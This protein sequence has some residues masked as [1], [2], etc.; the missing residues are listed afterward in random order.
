MRVVFLGTP[1]FA[2]PSLKALAEAED[3][4]VELVIT[5]PD[6]PRS[7]NKWTPTPVKLCAEELGLPV[8]TPEKVNTRE[9][10]DLLRELAPDALVVI[11]YG[12]IIGKTL[13]SMFPDR[14]INI[15]GS[16]LPEYR[17]AAPIQ[18]AM[19][20]GKKETGLTSMLIER[21]MDA[22][23][24]LDKRVTPIAEDDDINT[25]T[26]RLANLAPELLL[27]TLR[28]IEERVQGAQ[29]QD[30]SLVTFAEKITREDGVLDFRNPV[31]KL[32][33]QVR[34][35]L[36]WPCATFVLNGEIYKVHEASIREAKGQAAPGTIV[37]AKDA[38]AIRAADG[39]LVI[40]KIQAPN[41]KAM[42]AA[43]FLRGHAMETGIAV[44]LPSSESHG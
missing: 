30:E 17:G 25:L 10:W 33:D 8:I 24:M 12:Q 3:F 20:D 40:T 35:L 29:T 28:N 13:L 34:A 19:L 5:Q 11:A 23:A 36:G 39:D 27:D 43:D 44:E 18:R 16:L 14:I 41:R 6:R 1:E 26:D 9:I 22:G 7:R 32:R 4:D 38:L 42:A 15:H 21:R 31:R 2:V 37:E